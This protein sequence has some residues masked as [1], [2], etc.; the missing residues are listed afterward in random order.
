MSSRFAL[1][2]EDDKDA[3]TMFAIALQTA[4]FEAEIIRAGDTALARLAVLVP[5]LVVLDLHLPRV[6]GID[7]LRQI[8]ADARLAETRVIIITGDPLAAE[9]LQNQADL[10]LIKPISFD[11]LHDLAARLAARPRKSARER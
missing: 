11:Q 3:A 7:V 4:G 9:G 6:E 10:V 1:V 2:I 5:D 8:R